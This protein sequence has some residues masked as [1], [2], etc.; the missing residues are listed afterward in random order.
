MPLS[1]WITKQATKTWMSY[2]HDPAKG[3]LHLGAIGWVL[4]SAAQTFMIVTN[5]DIDKDK[6]KFLVPQELT[7]G[8]VN[9]TLYYTITAAIK[10]FADGLVENGHIIGEKTEEF[11][12]N[13]KNNTQTV[14][15]FVQGVS[16]AFDGLKITDTINRKQPMSGAF[17]G[18]QKMIKS[19]DF[20]AIRKEKYK[21]ILINSFDHF[22]TEDKAK[23]TLELLKSG[24]EEFSKLKSSVNVIATIVG[25]VIASS[26]IVPLVRNKV[27]N[28]YQQKTLEKKQTQTPQI[29]YNPIYKIPD[30]SVFSK[31]AI[32][33]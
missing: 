9:V 33:R 3:L 14:T 18:I 10:K 25:S 20:V 27:A 21:S 1:N 6:K 22:N 19:V 16:E 15:T 13:F 17:D 11:F 24:Q 2:S 4:S 26:I 29:Q 30:S 32:S 5:K 23:K 8:A 28:S 31:L 12:R 7:D